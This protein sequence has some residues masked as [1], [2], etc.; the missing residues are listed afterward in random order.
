W[1][2]SFSSFIDDVS[3]AFQ[4]SRSALAY[5]FVAVGG[6]SAWAVAYINASRELDQVG[7]APM[8]RPVTNAISVLAFDEGTSFLGLDTGNL[9]AR[10]IPMLPWLPLGLYLIVGLFVGLST[11]LVISYFYR[12]SMGIYDQALRS[13]VISDEAISQKRDKVRAEVVRLHAHA[14]LMPAF[15]TGVL[16]AIVWPIFLLLLILPRIK[17]WVISLIQSVG[18]F[19]IKNQKVRETLEWLASDDG[20]AIEEKDA[21]WQLRR[22]YQFRAII[23]WCIVGL[24]VVLPFAFTPAI[25]A[26]TK[27]LNPQ[28]SMASSMPI[29]D[30]QSAYIH[31]SLQACSPG[32]TEL[33]STGARYLRLGE[34]GETGPSRLVLQADDIAATGLAAESR[35]G[36]ILIARDNGTWGL[37]KRGDQGTASGGFRPVE[38]VSGLNV[39]AATPSNAETIVEPAYLNVRL[40]VREGADLPEGL[41]AAE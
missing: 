8:L 4:H 33:P 19:R 21:D 34:P 6:L 10:T 29:T 13:E 17:S 7:G 32:Y 28:V 35:E 16:A 5:L 39:V 24:S 41:A 12:N 31:L 27:D 9:F 36:N 30:A 26:L 3:S 22:A 2:N 23:A 37:V 18:R 20:N 25:H 38:I 1:N 11:M 14:A 15:V 40:C